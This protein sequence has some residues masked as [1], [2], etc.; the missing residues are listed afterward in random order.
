MLVE[1]RI[2]DVAIGSRIM[3]EVKIDGTTWD[4]PLIVLGLSSDNDSILLLSEFVLLQMAMNQNDV[5]KYFGCDVDIFLENKFK[6]EYISDELRQS[7]VK[8]AIVTRQNGSSIIGNRSVF[9]L[10]T[11]ELGLNNV[12]GEGCNYIQAIRFGMGEVDEFETRRAYGLDGRAHY[13]W[14]RTAYTT[15]DFRY[16]LRS[17]YFSNDNASYPD[18]WLRPCFSV[19]LDTIVVMERDNRLLPNVYRL[20]RTLETFNENLFLK[21]LSVKN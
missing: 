17:G 10:S 20:G 3:S 1:K 8:T 12:L 5:A 16:V 21:L 18:Y 2:S 13:Y 7:L 11:S 9:L 19:S 14:T 4:M 15:S 6:D